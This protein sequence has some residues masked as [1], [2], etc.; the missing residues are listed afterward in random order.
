MSDNINLDPNSVK[1]FDQKNYLK[2]Y[3]HLP[4][5]FPRFERIRTMMNSR[6]TNPG[7]ANV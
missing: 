1:V 3:R 4:K 7:A 2:L 5:L 6:R